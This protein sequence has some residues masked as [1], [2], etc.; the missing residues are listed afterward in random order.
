MMNV[1]F[2]IGLRVAE[3]FVGSPMQQ[4]LCQSPIFSVLNRL[5]PIQN[6]GL[7]LNLIALNRMP[8][9]TVDALTVKLTGKTH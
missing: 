7:G 9:T 6:K 2:E 5:N 3:P 1:R 8:S 4:E